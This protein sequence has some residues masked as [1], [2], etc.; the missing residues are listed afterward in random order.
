MGPLR[1]RRA[2]GLVIALVG[3]AP[4]RRDGAPPE[5][6]PPVDAC[7]ASWFGDADGDGHGDPSTEVRACIQP[8]NTVTLGDDC[9]DSDGDRYPGAPELCDGIDDDCSAATVEACPPGC[10]PLRHPVADAPGTYLLCASAASWPTAQATC[11]AAGMHLIQIDSSGE[12][13]WLHA[14]AI[15]VFGPAAFVLIG[16]TDQGAEGNWRWVGSNVAFW[17]GGPNGVPVGGRFVAW[18]GGEPNNGDGDGSEQCALMRSDG[19]WDDDPC[20]DVW[21]FVCER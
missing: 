17:Q 2:L 18:R 12:N 14:A 7:T 19:T 15:S 8:R 21:P 5:E 3:C 4:L 1:S 16:G 11:T 10:Q 6:A 9:D 20:G 13:A